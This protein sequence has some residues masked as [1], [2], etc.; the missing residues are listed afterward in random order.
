MSGVAPIELPV[1]FPG[2]SASFVFPEAA[3][4]LMGVYLLHTIYNTG[5]VA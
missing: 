2:V 1:T 3:Q 4:E 5:F